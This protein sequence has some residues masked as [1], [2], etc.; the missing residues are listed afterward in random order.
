MGEIL[1]E[2]RGLSKGFPGVWEHLILD[3]LDFDVRAGEVHTLLGENG[4][5][6][7]VIANILSGY[8]DKTEGEVLIRGNPV[9][10]T[11]P[12]DGLAHGI[13][14]VHQELM[15]VPA[16][17]VA[18]NVMVGLKAPAFSF[19]LAQVERRLDELVVRYGLQVD[20]RARVED[21][22]AGEQQRVEILKVLFHEPQVLLLDEPTSLLTPG[23]ADQ[24]F[25]VLRAMAD[26]GKG[27]VFISHKMREVFAVSDRVT[28]L[29]LGKMQGT[30]HISETTEDELTRRTFG[31]TVPDYM[32]RPAVSSDAPAIEVRELVPKGLGSK[33][34]ATGMSFRLRRGEI[35]GLAG[36]AGNGQ[37]ELIEA[38]TGLVPPAGGEVWILGEDL[39]NTA[40][41]LALALRQSVRNKAFEMAADLRL[42]SWQDAAVRNLAQDQRSPL[43]I[44]DSGNTRLEDVAEENITLAPADIARLG[45]AVAASISGHATSDLDPE[46][47]G[48][49]QAI[50]T[51]LRAAKRPLI[52]SGTSC[53]NAEVMYA[54]AEVASALSQS[55]QQTMLTLTVPEANSLGQAMLA[56][57]ASRSLSELAES[58]RSN[59]FD[60][61]VILEND[62]YR[63]APV[64][65]VEHLLASADTVI[66]LDGLDNRTTSAAN[67]VLP[68]ASFAETEGTLVS[69]EGRAQRHYPVF[70]PKGERRPAWVWLLACSKELGLTTVTDLHHFDDITRDCAASIPNLA[71]ITGAAPDHHFRNAGVKIPRQPH[72]YS[73][74][75]AMRADVS[76]HEPKQ[77]VD[78][79]SPLAF[80]MEGLNRSQPGALLPFVWAPGWNSNQSLHRFQSE[81]GGPLRGGT[82]GMRLLGPGKAKPTG[83]RK[84]SPA[85][86]PTQG[87]WQLV[88]RYRIF[89]S[90]ELSALSP[91]VAELCEN[92]YLEMRADDAA[93]LDVNEGDG[94]NLNNGLATLEV[95]INDS[96]PAGCVGY[97]AGHA[98][99]E[100][101]VAGNNTSLQKAENWKRTRPQLIGSDRNGGGH[102]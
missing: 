36:V 12:R 56:G 33:A 44:A 75:T 19:G 30:C 87:Q 62:L 42:E 50:S 57:P 59:N 48:H 100:N 52:I 77:P 54:A 11:S 6:K 73:G 17:T 97:T 14:M 20:P 91:G 34:P 7:T 80:T 98:A 51:A 60:V 15:L 35:L 41:R 55:G 9:N 29:K 101:L 49:V 85:F 4:A 71:G 66:V 31:E 93:K 72:R 2:A 69:L 27:I 88:P 99:T 84:N 21:L 86:S 47:A 63:R 3:H 79:E 45:M 26:E 83:T 53:G 28:V 67:L 90:E 16:F 92:G 82:A 25:V 18:Q 23:E 68:A 46:I 22:S 78:E 5:G 38:I 43:F 76:V 96:I 10:L 40:P 24:L 95:R 13:A 94:L 74:R 64:P 32:E 65:E 39:T 58:S 1:L 89:G 8:Y 61:L 102:D 81:V 70:L 37:T